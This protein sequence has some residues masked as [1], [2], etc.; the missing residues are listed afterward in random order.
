MT[1]RT[2]DRALPTALPLQH[3][4]VLDFFA[5]GGG[6]SAEA[7]ILAKAKRLEAKHKGTWPKSRSPLRSRGFQK[8]RPEAVGESV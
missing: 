3:G 2:R 8:T 5:G 4:I 7:P 1:D 6:A